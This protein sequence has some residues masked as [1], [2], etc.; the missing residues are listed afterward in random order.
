MVLAMWIDLPLWAGLGVERKSGW[1]DREP[2]GH[3]RKRENSNVKHGFSIRQSLSRRV[4]HPLLNQVCYC[5]LLAAGYWLR[6][7]GKTKTYRKVL[8]AAADSG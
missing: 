4:A 5:E 1:G 3:N 7:E 6:A 8:S 2:N